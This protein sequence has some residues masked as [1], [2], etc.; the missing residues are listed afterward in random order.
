MKIKATTKSYKDVT[1]IKIPEHKKPKR[2]SFLLRSLI[3]V[4]AFFDLKKAHFTT[5][6]ELPSKKDGPYLVLMNHSSFIDL[7]IAEKIMYPRPVS[8]V[9]SYDALVGKN[10][11]M[12][13][14]GCIPTRKFVN[15]IALIRDMKYSLG[16]GYNVLMFP[17]AGYSFDGTATAMPKIAKLVK[18]LGVPVVMVK[19]SGAFTMDPL[20]NGLRVRDVPVS[21]DISTLFTA[22]DVKN[23]PTEEMDEAIKSAFTFD[24]FRWQRDNKISVTSPERAVGLEKVL[25]RCPACGKEGAMKSEGDHIFCS[26]CGKTY[27]LEEFGN[28]RATEGVTE[29]DHIPDWYEWERQTVREEILREEYHLDVPVKISMMNDFKILYNVGEGRL[30]H[31]ASGFRLVGCGGELD[32][33]QKALFSHTVNSDF[34]W[35][36]LGD[37]VSIGDT[38]ALYYCFPKVD[39]P[40]AKVRLAAEELHKLH[41]D[42]E[43]RK[44]HCDECQTCVPK[45]EFATI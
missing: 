7:E 42:K 28:L 19:T 34:F 39:I 10:M 25:Y 24:A 18:L 3:N 14:I 33:V 32:Y 12:R 17:E 11:L 8:I 4:I 45:C 15:D 29:F 27:V 21:A 43:F 44:T 23:M 6:G 26:D 31:T 5:T 16:R 41:Q 1:S 35:Y 2:P 20:Y 9:C 30:T 13:H 22:D 36:E 38:N 40:V 37:I